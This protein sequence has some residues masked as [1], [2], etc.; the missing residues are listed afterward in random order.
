MNEID[1]DR[2]NVWWNAIW[3]IE[4]RWMIVLIEVL[5]LFFSWTLSSEIFIKKLLYAV[6]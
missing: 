4:R 1:S 6:D 3:W 2:R 5:E